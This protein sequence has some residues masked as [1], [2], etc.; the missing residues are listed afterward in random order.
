MSALT[1][2][3]PEY[4]ARKERWRY[5]LDHYDG[6]VLDDLPAYLQRHSQGETEAAYRE[7]QKI[8]DYTPHFAFAVDSLAGQMFTV[9]SEAMRSWQLADEDGNLILRDALGD[10]SDTESIMWRI[11]QNIDGKG[12]GYP[13]LWKQLTA[14]L[15]CLHEYWVLVEGVATSEGGE[16]TGEA[17]IHLISP[18]DVL[19]W[20]EEG[21]S[22]LWAKVRHRVYERSGWR[23]EAQEAVQY[24][25]YTLD[26]WT[27]YR[28][29]DGGET[30][31]ASGTYQYFE[32]QRKRRR[33]LPI[34]R[35]K[36]PLDRPVGY[37]MATKANAIFNL[38]SSRDFLL[39]SANFIRL[40][41]E[42]DLTDEEVNKR[43]G[44]G[45]NWFRA[46]AL[47]FV[48]PSSEPAKN[49]TDVLENKLE[50]FY[51]TFFRSYSDAARERTATE[52]RQDIQSGVEAFLTLLK[53]AIDDAENFALWLLE[54]TYFP[55]NPAAWGQASVE[56]SDRF[57]PENPDVVADHLVNRYLV[58]KVPAGRKALVNV[59]KKLLEM[60]RVDYDPVELQ[61]EI[62][63]W[64]TVPA[65]GGEE[66]GITRREVDSIATI[67][68]RIEQL[69]TRSET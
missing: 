39:W 52:I 28:E 50:A 1:H 10:P 17:R 57:Q 54:Q 2:E 65:E 9:E 43:L 63:E 8:V 64:L 3:H 25:L 29:D 44:E 40:R 5:A 7:R 41:L 16:P 42:T 22:L 24:T 33:I 47:D 66:D 48:N 13:T 15:I 37:V 34:Q 55:D 45:W 18:L 35:F 46:Q 32:T 38:E 23:T 30:L 59:V 51:R 49:A 12:T 58:T 68:R 67:R 31:I 20:E 56:R 36:V 53:S 14:R 11:W 69:Q 26:G 60:D 27:R 6:G 19:D 4:K 21:G 61:Q 62:D